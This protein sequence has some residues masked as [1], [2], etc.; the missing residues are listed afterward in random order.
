MKTII[1]TFF[2]FSSSK[3]KSFCVS[4]VGV[5]LWNNSIDVTLKGSKAYVIDSVQEAID[6]NTD[7]Y[8]KIVC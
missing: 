6:K 1:F 2:D 8:M 3:L 5:K 4:I 7:N